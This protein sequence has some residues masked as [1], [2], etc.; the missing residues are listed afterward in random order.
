MTILI[1]YPSVGCPVMSSPAAVPGVSGQGW[2][3]VVCDYQSVTSQPSQ[4][5]QGGQADNC[6]LLYSTVGEKRADSFYKWAVI[7]REENNYDK[8]MSGQPA[9]LTHHD[10]LQLWIGNINFN[11]W[12]FLTL[13]SR[14]QQEKTFLDELDG[15]VR[16]HISINTLFFY[17]GFYF[18]AK[19]VRF[20]VCSVF[21]DQ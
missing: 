9:F 18:I 11:W 16:I 10:N 15:V 4:S 21:S 1:K 6:Q 14:G 19:S 8:K 13:G 12:V 20:V 5:Y 2:T 3:L 7:S 17:F